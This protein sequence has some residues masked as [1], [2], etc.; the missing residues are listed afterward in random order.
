MSLRATRA[1]INSAAFI[2]NL[3]IFRQKI[4]A[5]KLCLAVKA[6]A[7]GHGLVPIA[8]L[9]QDNNID[10]LAVAG[11]DEGI[12]LRRAGITTPI[13]VLSP[14]VRQ[15]VSLI[16]QYKLTPMLT[17]L[18]YLEDI[19]KFSLQYNH[20]LPIHIKINTGMNRVGFSATSVREQLK[21]L[22][23]NPAVSIVGI[24]SHF[25][26][27]DEKT[28]AS[29][30]Q[31]TK[32]IK[33]FQRVLDELQ[34]LLDKDV[35]IHMANT[36]A[37]INFA[38]S[39]YDMVRV[40]IGAYGYPL[41]QDLGLRPILNFKTKVVYSQKIAKGEIVS[42][43]GTWVAP[44]D[45]NIA[46]LPVGYG[47]GYPRA[48]SNKGSVKIED[49]YFPIIGAVCMD[50]LMINTG[51]QLIPKETDVLIMGDDQLLNAEQLAKKI[52]GISYEMLTSISER[53]PRLFL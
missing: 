30:Q 18:D 52:N 20:R 13:L 43:G 44:E 46:L 51:D 28:E 38:E 29:I 34:D 27:A 26:C 39:H 11:V 45:T 1:E 25:A 50:M 23:D 35:I 22:W 41:D 6:N 3:N 15:E 2:S 24:G 19:E 53:V 10:M 36:S 7:Y 49:Q 47:D 48:L 37:T 8:Q 32:Q 40:G 31:T 16:F 12:A 14:F 17:H 42:Y 5:K 9:A 33:L 21:D 4:G